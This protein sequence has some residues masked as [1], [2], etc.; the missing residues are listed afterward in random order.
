MADPGWLAALLAGAGPDV[1]V[2]G[3]SMGNARR[4]R[5]T[6]CGAFFAEYG[7][8]G[9][10]RR[11]DPPGALPLVTGA[12]V[13]YHRT[14]VGE[15]AAWATEGSWENVI[16]QR[17]SAS[18]HRFRLVPGARVRQNQT[19]RLAGFC[20]D[21]FDHGRDFAATRAVGLPA[22]RRAVLCAGTPALPPILGA[23]IARSVDAEERKYFGKALPA[24]LTFLSAWALG[25]ATGY[26]LGA[27]PQ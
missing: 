24:T 22:W 1:Q 26:A 17:L 7:F 6:A 23:R 5:A 16:H 3:G 14:V 2:L 4:E 25:E 8:F 13:A 27:A 20:R 19:Y 15:V 18:G 11:A 21:R 10:N 12:N 9:A